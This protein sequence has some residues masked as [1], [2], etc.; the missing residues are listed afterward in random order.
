MTQCDRIVTL[1]PAQNHNSLYAKRGEKAQD[2]TPTSVRALK[3]LLIVRD[4][5]AGH[6]NVVNAPPTG[7]VVRLIRTATHRGRRGARSARHEEGAYPGSIRPL[8]LMAQCRPWTGCIGG[9]MRPSV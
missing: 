8:E 1:C 9:R 5:Q 3:T 7:C 2:K 4:S 6:R